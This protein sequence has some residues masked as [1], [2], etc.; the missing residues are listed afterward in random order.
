MDFLK[1]RPHLEDFF[2]LFRGCGK[3]IAGGQKRAPAPAQ[4]QRVRPFGRGA[5]GFPAAGSLRMPHNVALAD[6]FQRVGNPSGRNVAAQ[7]VTPERVRMQVMRH[8][9]KIPTKNYPF[10]AYNHKI[11]F[12]PLTSQRQ[13]ERQKTRDRHPKTWIICHGKEGGTHVD[14]LPLSATQRG[15]R[16]SSVIWRIC[17]Y[18]QRR[19]WRE[20]SAV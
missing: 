8:K 18:K 9:R 2:G 10:S 6:F 16:K 15:G 1:K 14:R 5:Q 17:M 11:P 7:H 13:I 19:I 4:R 12:P 20:K 3:D